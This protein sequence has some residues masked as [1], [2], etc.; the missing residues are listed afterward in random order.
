MFKSEQPATRSHLA[1]LA[2][3]M[4]IVLAVPLLP[5][6]AT[7]EGSHINSVDPLKAKV[8]DVVRATGEGLGKSAVDQLYLT[9]SD[10][11]V[12]VAITDQTETTITFKI[13]IGIKSGRWALM[14]HMKAS[15]GT[16]LYE[17]PVKVTVE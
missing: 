17:Q 6:P 16:G 9:N 11:D 3:I 1:T 10:Q 4:F 14:I 8:G 13:P 5:L 2:P 12:N 7:A 15:T